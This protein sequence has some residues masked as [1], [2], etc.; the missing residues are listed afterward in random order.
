MRPAGYPRKRPINWRFV[1]D[2]L[3]YR[4]EVRNL[5]HAGFVECR[6]YV[7]LPFDDAQMPQHDRRIVETRI[8]N[9]GKALWV[10]VEE[11]GSNHGKT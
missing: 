2:A 8:A 6:S 1:K 3:R 9:D 10:R 5:K 4:R 11:A 7:R